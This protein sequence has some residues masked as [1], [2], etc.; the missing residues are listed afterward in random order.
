MEQFYITLLSDS[1]I[2]LYPEN[3]LS[4]FRADL[5][6]PVHLQTGSWVVGLSEVSYSRGFT[7][8]DGRTY[9]KVDRVDKKCRT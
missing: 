7:S 9:K 6:R 5:A 3:S 8:R 1:S 2:N 4:S